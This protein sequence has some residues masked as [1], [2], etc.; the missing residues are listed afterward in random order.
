MDENDIQD[1]YHTYGPW[2]DRAEPLDR[3]V[4]GRYRRRQFAAV[5]GRV[6]DVACGTGTNFPYLHKSVDLVGVDLSRTMLTRARSRLE[7][8]GIDGTLA[9]MDAATLGFP[10]GSFDVVISALSTCTF[11]EPVRSIE[12]MARVCRDDGHIHLL[13]HGK[14]NIGPIARIQ[15]RFDE[16][17]YH[18]MGCRWTH[19]PTDHVESAGLEIDAVEYGPLGIVTRITARP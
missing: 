12:E 9:R 10:D 3:L 7:E 4:F 13:E 16:A 19:H 14:S 11:P 18:R 1:V 8:L 15:E 2:L 6:L 17:H 5:R